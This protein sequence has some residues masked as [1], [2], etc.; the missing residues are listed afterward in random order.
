MV[1]TCSIRSEEAI[2]AA[3]VRLVLRISF[4]YLFFSESVVYSDSVIKHTNIETELQAMIAA[5]DV[6]LEEVSS[7]NCPLAS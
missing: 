5:T 3:S 2:H 4:L 7:I 6:P 1:L